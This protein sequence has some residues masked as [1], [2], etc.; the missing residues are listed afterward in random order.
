MIVIKNKAA[1]E[2]MYRAGQSM[3]QIM[4]EVKNY[5]VPGSTT[6]QIDSFIEKA[7]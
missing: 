6:L 2:K 5:C 7:C 1:I 3:A 4:E